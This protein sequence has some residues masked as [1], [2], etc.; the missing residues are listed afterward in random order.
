MMARLIESEGRWIRALLIL[1]TVT[2][3]LVLAGLVAQYVLYFS[4]IILMLVMAWL[5]AFVLSPLVTLM[6]RALPGVPRN[7][8]V[9]SVYALL[10]LMLSRGR[11]ASSPRSWP[12]RSRASSTTCPRLQ[13]QLPEIL[14]PYQAQLAELGFQVDLVERRERG[15]DRHRGLRGDVRGPAPAARAGEPGHARATCCSWSSCRS[16]SSSTR[17]GSRVRQPHHAAALRRRD[18]PVPDARR[19]LLRR[20]HP[21]PGDPGRHLRR[22]RRRRAASRSASTTRR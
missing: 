13:E 22:D 16:S 7:V 10:F 8:V 9:V 20:L 15:P 3:A 14:A 4:D 1:S 6:R 2:V 19:V 11:A 5:F 18:A 12:A 21:R 17:S